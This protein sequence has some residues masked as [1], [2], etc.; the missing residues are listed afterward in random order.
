MREQKDMRHA[1]LS[2]GL[3]EIIGFSLLVAHLVCR[4]DFL[5][6]LLFQLIRCFGANMCL[7]NDLDLLGSSAPPA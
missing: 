2:C 1:N 3:H 4:C 6:E 5:M 7:K